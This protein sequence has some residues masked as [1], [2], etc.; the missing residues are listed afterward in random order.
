MLAPSLESG[1]ECREILRQLILGDILHHISNIIEVSP[2]CVK[3][4]RRRGGGFVSILI[5]YSHF[6]LISSLLSKFR[7]GSYLEIVLRKDIRYGSIGVELNSPFMEELL[8][9]IK[10]FIVMLDVDSWI[11]DDKEAI[12]LKGLSYFLTI[13]GIVA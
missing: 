12:F 2:F 5:V 11:L 4:R 7:C 10:E 6:F 9:K 13:L 1:S 3:R 8:H